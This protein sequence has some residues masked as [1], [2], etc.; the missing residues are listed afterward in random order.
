MKDYSSWTLKGLDPFN[1]EL[2]FDESEI[3][4]QRNLNIYWMQTF[5][6]FWVMITLISTCLRSFDKGHQ[7]LFYICISLEIVLFF[8]LIFTIIRLLK[9]RKKNNR[10]Y[11]LTEI[12][13]VHAEIKNY[14][15]WLTIDF[16]D[17]TNDKIPVIKNNLYSIFIDVIKKN[18]ID[19]IEIDNSKNN[20][21][22]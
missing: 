21:I 1:G 22:T 10:V 9:A 8:L 19:V 6:S 17:E 13:C 15:A 16:K 4:I 12:K 18:G 7:V 2:I 14:K 3:S 5:I 11:T 20:A